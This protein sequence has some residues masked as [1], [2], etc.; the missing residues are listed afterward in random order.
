M[1]ENSCI[2]S[3]L[4]EEMKT[5]DSS[6]LEEYCYKGLSEKEKTELTK[7]GFEIHSGKV[8][9]CVIKENSFTMIHTD[10]LSAFDHFICHIPF[11]GLLLSKINLFW[12]KKAKNAGFP[13]PHFSE[14]RD[15]VIEMENLKLFPL[16]IV[17]RGYLAG[18]MLRAY[19]KNERNFCHN[20][21]EMDLKPWSKLSSPIVTPTTKAKIGEHDENTTP[22]EIIKKGQCTK[23]E[24]EK[25]EKLA[26]SL[27]EFGRKHYDTL[28]WILVDTKY[29]FGQDA[30]GNIFL[31][32]ELHT[33]DSSRLWE[34]SSYKKNI[35]ASLPPKMLDKEVIRRYL[36]EK[37]FQGKG[38]V[39]EIPHHK[40]I[41]LAEV[42]LEVAK[43]LE[44]F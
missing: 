17:V 23:D 11:K 37:G 4:L 39:P 22:E 5:K 9:D 29:E 27:Y 38:I 8:R 25:I 7:N 32:D 14:P 10:R 19:E 13:I 24:W 28:G 43:K 34:K 15:R 30:E 35:E 26:L 40:K 16:E 44:C 2:I 33:P 18:S 12:L 3:S 1:S 42:Y 31:G 36:I 20:T 6:F 21:L 41:S